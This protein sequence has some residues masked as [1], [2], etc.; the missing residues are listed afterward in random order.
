MYTK[1]IQPMFK[2]P[3]SQKTIEKLLNNYE[4]NWRQLNLI[5][6]KVTID[7]SL[8]I[9]HYKILNNI[10]YLNE[11]LSKIDPTV[12]SLCSLCKKAPEGVMHL[13]CECPIA[14]FLWNSLQKTLSSLL[15]LLLLDPFI[16]IVG[17]GDIDNPNNVLVNHI[18]LLFKS[19]LSEQK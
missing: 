2:P 8:R 17:R 1:L 19:F 7:T 18:V 15:T 14:K 10:L 13:F 9:F 11:R 16:S 3:T 6:Q 5:P 4:V 12:S